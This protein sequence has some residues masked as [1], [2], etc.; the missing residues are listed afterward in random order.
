MKKISDE[1]HLQGKLAM[2]NGH[3]WNPFAA[4]NLDLFGA[5]LS[6]YSSDD[7]NTEALISKEPSHFRNQLFFCS[8]RD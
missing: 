2:G 5:E 6:W 3:G 8:M 4:A 7:H 1:M